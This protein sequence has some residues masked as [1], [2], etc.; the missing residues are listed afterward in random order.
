MTT[1][2][3]WNLAEQLSRTMA[4]QCRY[5]REQKIAELLKES[6]AVAA[7]IQELERRA[8]GM[9]EQKATRE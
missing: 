3:L 9:P 2:Q 6:R 8:L 7:A 4:H 1:A 5:E